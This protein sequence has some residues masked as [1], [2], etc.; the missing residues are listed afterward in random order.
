MNTAHSC[1]KCRAEIFTELLDFIM[2]NVCCTQTPGAGAQCLQ[3]SGSL[4][5][6]TQLWGGDF[7]KAEREEVQSSTRRGR[8]AA[9]RWAA[10]AAAVGAEGMRGLDRLLLSPVCSCG[11]LFSCSGVTGQEGLSPPKECQGPPPCSLTPT[12]DPTVPSCSASRRAHS[13][14]SGLP[15]DT[16][17]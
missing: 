2:Q 3:V 11:C 15:R 13:A 16:W 6:G 9:G 10:G 14:L 8:W 17:R 1:F 5:R 12:A 7:R 4:L